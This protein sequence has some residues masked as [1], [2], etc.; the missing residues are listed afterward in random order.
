MDWTELIP[1]MT[2]SG[3]SVLVM[4]LLASDKAHA[5][6]NMKFRKD[7]RTCNMKTTERRTGAR[8]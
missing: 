6:I 8:G 4:L 3:G 5:K 7:R 1:V 2:G